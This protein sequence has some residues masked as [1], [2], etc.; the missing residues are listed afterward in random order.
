MRVPEADADEMVARYDRCFEACEFEEAERGS[1]VRREP[2]LAP[3]SERAICDVW[4]SSVP[5]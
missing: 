2:Q 4:I 3:S 5:A 1:P